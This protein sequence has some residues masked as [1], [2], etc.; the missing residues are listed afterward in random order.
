MLH[1]ALAFF[2]AYERDVPGAKSWLTSGQIDRVSMGVATI[3]AR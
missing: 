2:D 3:S 1:T